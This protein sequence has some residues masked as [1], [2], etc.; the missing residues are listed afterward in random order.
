MTLASVDIV[1]LID[2]I[3]QT[4]PQEREQLL[5]YSAALPEEL[6]FRVVSAGNDYYYGHQREHPNLNRSAKMYCGQIIELKHLHKADKT[7]IHRKCAKDDLPTMELIDHARIAAAARHTAKVPLA[8][9]L[10][11]CLPDLMALR[12]QGMSYRALSVW[13]KDN[14][15]IPISHESI[16]RLINEHK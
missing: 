5:R 9:Q 11:L 13:L 8:E 3:T 15:L 6:H 1:R 7:S 10:L 4:L 2:K 12:K 16:R 14:H